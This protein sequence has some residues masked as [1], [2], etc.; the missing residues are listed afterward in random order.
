MNNKI[1]CPVCLCESAC[2]RPRPSLFKCDI[3]GIYKISDTLDVDPPE[4]DTSRW[5]LDSLQR[6]VLSMRCPPH[7][8]EAGC[9]F[10][11][12]NLYHAILLKLRLRC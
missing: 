6:A 5:D 3:C 11:D 12:G 9:I 10:A 7:T 1:K 8:H 4:Y 2:Q